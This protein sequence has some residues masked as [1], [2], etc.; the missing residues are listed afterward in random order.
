MTAEQYARLSKVAEENKGIGRARLAKLTGVS[1]GVA[2]SFLNGASVPV[3]KLE[4]VVKPAK[5]ISVKDFL[6]KLDYPAQLAAAIKEHCRDAFIA[7]SD[8]RVLTKLNPNA[9]R[10]AVNSGVFAGNQFKGDGVVYWS[11]EENVRKAK[12][13]R[14][15]A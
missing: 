3:D 13:K 15:I 2:R 10:Q 11:T 6:H 14:G 12:E 8:F 4:V 9:F 7:E 1:E 5:G